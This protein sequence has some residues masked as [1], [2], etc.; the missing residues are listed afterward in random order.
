M[1]F[2]TFNTY[3]YLFSTSAN[4]IVFIFHDLLFIVHYS[5]FNIHYSILIIHYSLFHHSSFI[6][7]VCLLEFILYVYVLRKRCISG[8]IWKKEKKNLPFRFAILCVCVWHKWLST[9]CNKQMRCCLQV[10]LF[11]R[12]NYI[13]RASV[14]CAWCVERGVM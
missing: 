2:S 10:R 4:V 13:E 9:C 5:L 8:W 11:T 12:E 1:R 7:A 14:F 3:Y 6:Q